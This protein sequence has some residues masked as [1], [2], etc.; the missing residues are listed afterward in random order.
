M[1]I[2]FQPGE[3]RSRGLLRDCKICYASLLFVKVWSPVK[4]FDALTPCIAREQN[5][6][7]FV[8]NTFGMHTNVR[9]FIVQKCIAI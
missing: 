7:T 8:L 9:S 2:R 1:S 3:D 4:M 6:I 5:G